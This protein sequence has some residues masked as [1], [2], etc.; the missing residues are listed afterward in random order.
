MITKFK[1]QD[2]RFRNKESEMVKKDPISYFLYPIS[3]KSEGFSLVEMLVVMVVFSI[4]AIV[5]TQ[6]LVV[7]LRSSKKSESIVV[8]KQNVDYAQSTMERLLR[9]AQKITVC[10]A[11]GGDQ[12]DYL[13]ENNTTGRFR[14][15]TSGSDRYIA[16]GSAALVRLTSPEVQVSCGSVFKCSLNPNPNVPPSIEINLE[17]VLA[18]LGTGLEGAKVTS[19]TKILLRTY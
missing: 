6:T 10:S 19:S 4:L 7:S 17:A 1:I 16:S 5:T 14:C 9:N 12:I 11:T 2:S 18:G 13:D 15:V 8:V 3:R